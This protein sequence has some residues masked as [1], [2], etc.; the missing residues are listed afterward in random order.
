MDKAGKPDVYYTFFG[1]ASAFALGLYINNNHKRFLDSI[2]PSN[3]DLPNFAAYKG[4]LGLLKYFSIPKKMRSALVRSASRLPMKAKK[5]PLI[6]E[7]PLTPDSSPYTIFLSVMGSSLSADDHGLI[8]RAQVQIDAFHVDSGGWSN[9][10]GN[11][12]ASLNA[13][14]AA[15]T[16]FSV[17]FINFADKDMKWLKAQQLP[18]GGFLSTPGAPLP[19]LLSTATALIA[20]KMA[21]EKPNYPVMDFI[22][23]HW[24]SDG[25][26]A[27]TFM[28]EQTDCE[29]TFY[30]LLA[31]GASID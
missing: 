22:Q 5:N 14:A 30:G 9:I 27:S 3:L 25:G 24:R 4:S 23:A 31:L 1:L 8:S 16:L 29:Y 20:L 6:Q 11:S 10:K 19:D 12:E 28:D 26:F 2:D 21:G 15:I 18:S 7:F 17:A 13:T